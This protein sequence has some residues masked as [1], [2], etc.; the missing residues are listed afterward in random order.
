MRINLLPPQEKKKIAL[1]NFN[2]LLACLVFYLVIISAIF[3]ILLLS[4]Y[5]FL[6]IILNAQTDLIKFR[7]GGQK[8]QYLMTIEEKIKQADQQLEQ[9]YDKQKKFIFWT[10]LFEEFSR[11]VPSGIY[12]NN[13]SYRLSDNRIILSGRANKR[14]QLLDLQK[15]LEESSSFNKVEAPL[16]N[17]IK[18]TGINFSFTLYLQKA[19]AENPK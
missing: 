19:Q 11:I 1:A 9:I 6:S 10:P 4:V 15:R 2:H 14:E 3:I 8:I 12:L 7:Q 5:F 17:L 13:F 18:Q 16:S